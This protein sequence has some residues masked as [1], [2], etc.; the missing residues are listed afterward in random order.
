MR[1]AGP[2]ASLPL[3]DACVRCPALVAC[4]HGIVWGYGA[5]AARVMI[6]GEAPGETEDEQLRPFVG[7]SGRKLDWMLGLAGLTRADVFVT[8]VVK[9]WTGEGNPKPKAKEIAACR[10]YLEQELRLV[11]PA[12]VICMGTYSAAAFGLTT[13]LK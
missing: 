1:G 6:V 5:N 7:A 9:C 4:R 13:A 8:N 11:S 10:E 12:I 3:S 2:V